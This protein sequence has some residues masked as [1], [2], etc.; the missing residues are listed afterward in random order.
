MPLAEFKQGNF[1]RILGKAIGTDA[2]GRS[3]L[4]NQIFNPYSSR[5]VKDASGKDVTVRDPFTNNAIPASMISN[6]AKKVQEFY[7]APKLDT[8]FN[9]WNHAG[10]TKSNVRQYD[11]KIDLSLTH[12]DRL[13]A[14][15]GKN[16]SYNSS[17]QPYP[18]VDAGGLLTPPTS[19][20]SGI[21]QR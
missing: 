9:N 6:A 17:P 15:Y 18:N 12:K 4:Q 16:S 10:S 14:R 5:V 7:S 19:G 8:P 13:M 3:V 21:S 11:L 1:A 2:L 20:D